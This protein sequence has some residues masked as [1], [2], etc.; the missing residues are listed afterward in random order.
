MSRNQNESSNEKESLYHN[1][2]FACTTGETLRKAEVIVNSLTIYFF[3]YQ[4]I[5]IANNRKS[6]NGVRKKIKNKKTLRRE[7]N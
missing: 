1:K 4:L 6:F 2:I 7:Q 3:Y 5:T